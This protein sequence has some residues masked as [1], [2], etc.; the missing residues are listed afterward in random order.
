MLDLTIKSKLYAYGRIHLI[1]NL[2]RE[3]LSQDTEEIEL[4]TQ[5]E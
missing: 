3:D 4:E 2:D 5:S 1:K